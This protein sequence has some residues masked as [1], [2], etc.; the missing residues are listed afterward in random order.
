[1]LGYRVNKE[2]DTACSSYETFLGIPYV[3][4]MWEISRSNNTF[5]DQ[6]KT[7]RSLLFSFPAYHLWERGAFSH[8]MAFPPPFLPLSTPPFLPTFL[9]PPSLL[10]SAIFIQVPVMCQAMSKTQ[11]PFNVHR[12]I[13]QSWLHYR[14]TTEFNIPLIMI[15]IHRLC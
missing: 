13:L 14:T 12:C 7:S 3:Q 4:A 10:P 9:P 2:E 8:F 15:T 1:M 5:T 11:L 6:R